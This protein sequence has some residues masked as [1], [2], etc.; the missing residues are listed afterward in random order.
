MSSTKVLRFLVND[1][2]DFAQIRAGK[3]RKDISQFDI[4][5]AL[6]EIKLILLF[7]AEQSGIDIEMDFINFPEHEES[8]QDVI[9]KSDSTKD[10]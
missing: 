10:F 3:F 5:E 9:W 4:K 6:E 1:I 8:K 7:K 2:L